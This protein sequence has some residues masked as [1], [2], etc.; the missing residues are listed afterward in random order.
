MKPS[1]VVLWT[2]LGV[3]V[4]LNMLVGLVVMLVAGVIFVVERVKESE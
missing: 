3:F 1:A 2:G 4:F